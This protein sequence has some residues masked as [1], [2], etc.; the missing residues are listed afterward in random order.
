MRL[1]S[2]QI[3]GISSIILHPNFNYPN[4][5]DDIALVRLD[6]DVEWSEYAQPVC[7]PGYPRGGAAWGEQGEAHGMLAGWG[8]DAPARS[9]NPKW[10]EEL[11]MVRL[12]VLS[13][14]LCKEWFYDKE[15]WL[16]KKT[17]LTLQDKRRSLN[18]Y[19]LEKLYLT[20]GFSF[21][22]NQVYATK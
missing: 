5:E 9:T 11:Q 10:T 1:V 2:S 4:T 13:N 14:N 3:Y 15:Q 8:L 6:R 18:G 21:S 22:V 19:I 20:Y 7:L 12:P 16:N 17:H